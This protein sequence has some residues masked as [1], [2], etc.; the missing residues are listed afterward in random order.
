LI[1]PAQAAQILLDRRAARANLLDYT[2]LMNP[3]YV[4]AEFHKRTCLALEAIER[5]DID[6]LMIF[7]P[8]R[9]G[10]SELGSRSFPAWYLGKNPLRQVI[11]ASYS[12]DLAVDFGRDVRNAVNS[13]EYK[14]I[15][16]GTELAQ[17]S[18]AAN[19]WHTNQGGSYVAAGVGASITGRGADLLNIDDPI[20]DRREAD[21]KAVKD[22][23]WGW[24]RS[25]AY[26]RLMPKASIVCIQTRWAEDDLA[27]RILNQKGEKWEMIEF[28]AINDQGEALWPERY[29]IEELK[30]TRAVIGE[31]EFSALYQQKPM[32]D[33][34][35][36]FQRSWFGWYDPKELPEC[37]RYMTSDFAVTEDG[38][39]FT[40]IMTN[41]VDSN[42][43]IYVAIDYWTGQTSADKWIDEI[44]NQIIRNKPMAFFGEGGPIRRS[45]EP[46]LLK[47]MRERKAFCRVDWIPSIADKTSRARAFQARAS[48]GKVKLPNNEWG[49]SILSQLLSF[50]AGMQDDDV[51][52]LSLMG[53]IID[54]AHP[55]TI[56]TKVIERPKDRYDRLFEQQSEDISWRM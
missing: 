12:T 33:E 48:M 9:T 42:D 26:T 55:A 17:D 43:D 18:Q 29:P 46:F 39:D 27:G 15:F 34:G 54:E 23:L 45:I 2:M 16:P 44:C 6:R 28:P 19:R 5:G 47:R 40:T 1:T 25:T 35:T 8:P 30:R 7:M 41:G 36:F 4:A 20:K 37:K 53:R 38:G 52:T 3:R 10:K 49:Y 50:P 22:A 24:Y 13:P 14:A 51:D 31:R 56:T 11:C 21:S 32:P